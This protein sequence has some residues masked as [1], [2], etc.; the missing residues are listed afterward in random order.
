MPVYLTKEVSDVYLQSLIKAYREGY[1]DA[2][3]TNVEDSDQPIIN[4][5]TA[6]KVITPEQATTLGAAT[7]KKE[8]GA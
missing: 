5:L 4:E 3:G 1:T 2:G 6:H 8:Q 7:A